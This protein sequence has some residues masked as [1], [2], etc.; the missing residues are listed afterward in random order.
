MAGQHGDGGES[1]EQHIPFLPLLPEHICSGSSFWQAIPERQL[2]LQGPVQ[3]T[4]H[5]IN[6]PAAGFLE[7]KGSKVA[8]FFFAYFFILHVLEPNSTEE[9]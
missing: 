4:P 6:E 3:R 2:L 7:I 5:Y 8:A 1:V 9:H